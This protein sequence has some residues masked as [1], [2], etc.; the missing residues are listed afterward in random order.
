VALLE[1]VELPA[2][3]IAFKIRFTKARERTPDNRADFDE[4][5]ITLADDTWSSER[6]THVRTAKP[7]KLQA[8]DRVFELLAEAIA[9]DGEVVPSNRHVPPDA[10]GV[11]LDTWRRYCEAGCISEGDPDPVKKAAADRKAF[12]RA[13]NHLLAARRVG[14]WREWVW[15]A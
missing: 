11:R 10:R 13:S 5:I 7:T 4:A 2:A 15:I 3:D 9:I 14:M 8:A 1:R 6:S 12:W